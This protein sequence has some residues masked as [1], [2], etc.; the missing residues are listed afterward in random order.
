MI[1]VNL[2]VKDLSRSRAFYEGLGYSVNPQFSDEN[3]ACIVISDTI[4]AMLLTEP[5]F[6]TFT[7][8]EI[9]DAT[10]S[11]EV[12]LA[13]S[14]DSRDEVNSLVDKAVAGGGREARDVQDE[15]FMYS[16]AFEDPDGHIWEVMWMDMAA[17]EAQ[18][19]AATSA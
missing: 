14:A 5:F 16:R 10:R 15:G 6:K 17:F 18:Q 4:Y 19:A 1:F 2:P 7:K 11:T 3:A 12:L 9:A 13:L 8:K